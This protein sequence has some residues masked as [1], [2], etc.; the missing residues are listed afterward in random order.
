MTAVEAKP[1]NAARPRRV[2]RLRRLP[3]VCT[4]VAAVSVATMLAARRHDAG[5]PT[6]AFQK[7]VAALK[8]GDWSLAR[9]FV[10]EKA[11]QS[12]PQAS[13]LRG[14]MLLD[15]EYF[16]PA[17]EELAKGRQ[18]PGLEIAS[19]TLMA[20]AWYRLGRHVEARV[21]LHEVLRQKPDSIEG[22]RWLAASYYDLGDFRSAVDHL[23]RTAELDPNDAR[24]LRL[25]GLIYKDFSQ[26]KEAIAAYE[27]SLRRN[28]DQPDAADVRLELASC[29]VEDRRYRDALA[30]L[31]NCADRP[32]YEV[33]RAQCFYADGNMAAAKAA[34]DNA[35]DQ[36]G[37]N[38]DGLHFQGILL[39][40]AGDAREAIEP[41]RKAIEAYPQD[42][43]AHFKLSQAYGQIGNQEL[44]KAELEKS[45]EIR[46]LLDEFSRLHA[47]A[48]ERPDDG[49]VRLRL[50][51]LAKQLDRPEL[52]EVWLR[53]A[54]AL[55][56]LPGAVAE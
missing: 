35:L 43:V 22:H 21:A 42:Y 23:K 49:E 17:L 2:F 56:P 38:L 55:R 53:S 41:F 10:R 7:A 25:L 26:Y 19:H 48:W 5:S 14:A 16:Y 27:E 33:L 47:A 39:L 50:A 15:K 24:P 30:T 20:E 37:D 51:E 46:S 29:Q 18:A 1:E 12:T 40:E 11:L 4:A 8:R 32:E 36:Q 52:A 28:A 31:E 9:R 54:A 6:D 13:F 44:A 45:Q 34:L 3:L